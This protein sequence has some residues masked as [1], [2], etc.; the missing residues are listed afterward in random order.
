[1]GNDKN[2]NFSL[3][4]WTVNYNNCY[5]VPVGSLMSPLQLAIE[6]VPLLSTLHAG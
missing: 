6:I 3:Y 4:E 1:M 5:N 2:D